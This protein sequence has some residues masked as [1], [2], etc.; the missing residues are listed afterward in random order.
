MLIRSI[1]G[2]RSE[3]KSRLGTAQDAGETS[4]MNAPRTP[5]LI[6]ATVFG[7]VMP[8][9]GADTHPDSLP[10]KTIPVFLSPGEITEGIKVTC[11]PVFDL[12][13]KW[14]QEFPIQVLNL[15]PEEIFLEVTGYSDMAYA[16]SFEGDVASKR[17]GE[18]LQQWQIFS[19]SGGGGRVIF[20]DKASLL[21]R[22]HSSHR[23]PDGSWRT[24]ACAST[25]IDA[26]VDL[27][28]AADKLR[29][30]D[31]LDPAKT[32]VVLRL[33]LNGFF[34][35]NGQSFKGNVEIPF[36]VKESKKA[37]A[38]KGTSTIPTKPEPS[39]AAP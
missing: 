37:D 36:T 33:H 35:A 5:I 14:P 1:R 38:G 15:Q 13:G 6:I 3:V 34:R 26:A 12:D 8:T 22:L 28:S 11:A 4:K 29:D 21:K 25:T 2:Y 27:S 16:V 18:T 10:T 24:C 9:A 7:M 39:S 30:L 31:K 17:D 23:Q 20:P 32:K 19:T